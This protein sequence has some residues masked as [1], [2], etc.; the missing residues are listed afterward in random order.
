MNEFQNSN[1]VQLPVGAISAFAGQINNSGSK[2]LYQ[3]P[4]EEWGWMI[5][6]GRSLKISEY[7]ELYAVLGGLYGETKEEFIIPNF[8]GIFLRGVGTEP[9]SIEGRDS[10]KGGEENG[11]GST[12]KCAIQSHTHQYEKPTGA[13]P[14]NKGS[15]FA[16]VQTSNTSSPADDEG[17]VPGEV[18]VSAVETRPVNTFV[19]YIIKTTYGFCYPDR[20]W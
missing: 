4:I 1:F 8:Q 18:Y 19:Y 16:A 12:Q 17:N 10:A 14:G 9:P 7:P 6:D 5:C 11:V 20:V 13:S 3:S 2:E 15:A